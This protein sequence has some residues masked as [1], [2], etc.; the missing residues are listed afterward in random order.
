MLF[1]EVGMAAYL[2]GLDWISLQSLENQDIVN[3]GGLAEQFIGQHLITPFE[4]P[5]LTY[6]LRESGSANAEVDYVITRGNQIIPIE[7]K[8]G[9]S[10]TLKSLQQFVLNK[11]AALVVRFDLNPPGI[12]QV[13]HAART[14]SGSQTVSY[15]LLSLPLY[16]VEELQRILDEIRFKSI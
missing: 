1:M 6:W 9:K 2:C 16:M 13:R 5:K 4:S 8:A 11:H 12:Q 7:V 15:K 3:D 10:G 14:R